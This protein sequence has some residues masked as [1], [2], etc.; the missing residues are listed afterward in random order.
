MFLA[1]FVLVSSCDISDTNKIDQTEQV[2]NQITDT[3]KNQVSS[4]CHGMP[5]CEDKEGLS[6]K[7]APGSTREIIQRP[8]FLKQ[9]PKNYN[10]KI[11]LCG[12]NGLYRLLTCKNGKVDGISYAYD[13]EGGY[14]EQYYK[15]SIAEGTWVSYDQYGKYYFVRDFRHGKLHGKMS[16]YDKDNNYQLLS[17]E[18]F[19]DDE[20][21]GISKK[22]FNSGL[23]RE[24]KKY[25][26][27]ELV[28]SKTYY[29]NGQLKCEI[30]Y[31]VKGLPIIKYYDQQ[32]F[33]IGGT[34]EQDPIKIHRP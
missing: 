30:N 1:L 4:D 11:K 15:N 14:D 8:E 25:D 18:N 9:I 28:N 10:G 32:G 29:Q 7:W 17:E 2:A 22:Y 24:C 6:V 21:D 19:V 33:V 13:C 31:N 3:L 20:L 34:V 23:V 12:E 5:K 16:F 27:G 26:Q